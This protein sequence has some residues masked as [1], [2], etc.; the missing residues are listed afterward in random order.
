MEQLLRF[1]RGYFWWRREVVVGRNF[2][3][4]L[5]LRKVIKGNSSGICSDNRNYKRRLGEKE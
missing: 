3:I 5:K 1:L 4:G 2:R